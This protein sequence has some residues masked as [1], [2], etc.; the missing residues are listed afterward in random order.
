MNSDSTQDLKTQISLHQKIIPDHRGKQVKTIDENTSL[1]LAE[2]NGCH[3]RQIYMEALK[4]G[5]DPLR[6][7]RNRESISQQNQIKLAE[8]EVSIIGAGGLGGHVIL[9]L[10][11]IG[12]GRIIIFDRDVFDETNL[13][14]Q[15]LSS[16]TTV[17]IPKPDVASRIVAETNPAVEVVTHY[18]PFTPSNAQDTLKNSNIIVDA[19]DNAHDRLALGEVASQLGIPLVHGAVAGFEGRVM[20]IFP[21]D[22]G[23]KI[24]YDKEGSKK[25]K[26]AESVLGTPSIA[27]SLIG[28][29]QAMEVIKVLL[30]RGRILKNTI[31][32]VDLDNSEFSEY[33]F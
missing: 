13:N 28:S 18:I 11:R 24:L 4:I 17:D 21:G 27:P 6:Y 14:R 16:T 15:L 1:K 29:L 19:L 10:A 22:D 33:G 26:T 23:L 31:A 9:L 12:I 20:T 7:L 25:E 30:K 3:L 2:T 5:V 32:H 8:S